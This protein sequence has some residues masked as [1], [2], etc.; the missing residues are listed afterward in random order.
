MKKYSITA[1]IRVKNDLSEAK[2][3]F[4]SRR[5]GLGLQFLTDYRNSLFKLKINP[6][7]EI[8]YDDIRCLPF[9]TFQFMIHFKVDEINNSVLILGVISTHKDPNTNW[10]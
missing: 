10:L 6:L 9:E 8:R 5:K 7:Y 1:D 3:F 4:D 2:D